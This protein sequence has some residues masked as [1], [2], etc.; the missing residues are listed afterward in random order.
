MEQ[1]VSKFVMRPL[2]ADEGEIMDQTQRLIDEVL[3]L[4][5]KAPLA[6]AR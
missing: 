1:G 3:P 4:V 6:A 2:G 5:H